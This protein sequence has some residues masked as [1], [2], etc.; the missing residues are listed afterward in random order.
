L[1]PQRYPYGAWM[2]AALLLWG[3][4]IGVFFRLN[5][6]DLA[7]ATR[8]GSAAAGAIGLLV[9][10]QYRPLA[11]TVLAAAALWGALA[12]ESAAN[13]DIR[14]GDQNRLLIAGAILVIWMGAF[15]V[16]VRRAKSKSRRLAWSA[17]FVCGAQFVLLTLLMYLSNDHRAGWAVG[18]AAV[19]TLVILTIV[20][21]GF[22]RQY[23]AIY[24]A[25]LTTVVFEEDKRTLRPIF[26]GLALVAGLASGV[27]TIFKFVKGNVEA[28]VEAAVVCCPISLAMV[29]LAMGAPLLAG[30]IMRGSHEAHTLREPE[31]H[32]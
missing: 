18:A 15:V 20:E 10:Y 13:A 25:W 21:V 19:I 1:E 32:R 9:I 23:P 31:N 8:S 12:V 30:A 2:L 5:R 27:I 6:G 29:A 3:L 28:R 17:G 16:G 24:N 14:P 11:A 7:G 22:S 4:M 26:R